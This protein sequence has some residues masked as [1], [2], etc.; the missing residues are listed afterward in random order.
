MWAGP[1]RDHQSLPELS[2]DLTWLTERV[3]RGACSR[4]IEGIWG[5]E[6]GLMGRH[7]GCDEALGASS[8]HQWGASGIMVDVT[9]KRVS[10]LA[11]TYPS[12]PV[13][14]WLEDLQWHRKTFA[15]SRFR[16][17]ARDVIGVVTGHS[18]GQTE[19]T[20][21]EDLRALQRYRYAVLD[22]A[23]WT[24]NAMA[25]RLELARESLGEERWGSVTDGL[26]LTE[27]ECAH[28]MWFAAHEEERDSANIRRV[29]KFVPFRNPLIEA[30]ELKQLMRLWEAAA[31]MLEDTVCDVVEELLPTR[32]VAV[33]SEAIGTTSEN[34]L[35]QRV[36]LARE[37]RGHPGDPRRTPTQTF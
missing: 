27:L 22:Q 8:V 2:P 4:T 36:A 17:S 30:F 15:D 12:S 7:W 25:D 20:T 21:V 11:A 32:P 10:S 19:F 28:A 34:S 26:G 6:W 29:L 23:A 35:M 18:G 13:P 14:F 3:T 37:E 1:E 33:L 31:G 24:R 5:C 16:W 9:P